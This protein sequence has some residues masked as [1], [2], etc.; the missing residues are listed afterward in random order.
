MEW[1]KVKKIGP[2]EWPPDC[3]YYTFPRDR[4]FIALWDGDLVAMKWDDIDKNYWYF[5][6]A[7]DTNPDSQRMNLNHFH[8]FTHWLDIPP[9]PKD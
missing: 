9:K 6:G 8:Y 2:M 1:I 4:L 7:E 3:A 5:N